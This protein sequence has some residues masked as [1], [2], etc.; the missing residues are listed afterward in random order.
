MPQNVLLQLQLF[1]ILIS[2]MGGKNSQML[3]PPYLHQSHLGLKVR[4]FPS[5]PYFRFDS[6]LLMFTLSF[7][8]TAL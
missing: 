1:A 2:V 7:I 5:S 6:P 4:V 8:V 3:P